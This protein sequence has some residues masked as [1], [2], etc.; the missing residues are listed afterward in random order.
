MSHVTIT[1]IP[2][3]TCHQALC[4]MSNLRNDHVALSVLGERATLNKGKGETRR[5]EKRE[6][7]ISLPIKDM[8]SLPVI[9]LRV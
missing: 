1:F 9:V 8:A 2:L 4:R 7:N 5:D 3:F 6:P